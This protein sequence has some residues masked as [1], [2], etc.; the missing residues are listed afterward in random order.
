MYAHTCTHVSTHTCTYTHTHSHAHSTHVTKRQYLCSSGQ[1]II[2]L[3]AKDPCEL[4]GFS[5][6]VQLIQY[7]KLAANT[8]RVV[9]NDTPAVQAC[10]V[11]VPSCQTAKRVGR[12]TTVEDV[13]GT[14]LIAVNVERHLVER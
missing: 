5:N 13:E 7:G 8:L 6:D 9:V 1:H 14:I 4:A 3:D 11:I 10:A 2:E 12:H